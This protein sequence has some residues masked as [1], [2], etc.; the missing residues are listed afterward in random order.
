MLFRVAA[1]FFLIGVLKRMG[2]GPKYSPGQNF[3][4]Y[5]FHSENINEFNELYT[6][7]IHRLQTR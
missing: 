6:V 4:N 7:Y 3:H 2:N 1:I 5:S